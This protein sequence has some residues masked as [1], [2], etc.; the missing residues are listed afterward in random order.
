MFLG[1]LGI[2]S[3]SVTEHILIQDAKTENEDKQYS[4]NL[5][6]YFN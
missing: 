2:S 4:G 3:S 1:K 5:T 6:H